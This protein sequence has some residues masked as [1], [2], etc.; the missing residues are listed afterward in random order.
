MALLVCSS[1]LPLINQTVLEFLVN[2]L[3]PHYHSR[4]QKMAAHNRTPTLLHINRRDKAHFGVGFIF[5]RLDCYVSR[6]LAGCELTH[7]HPIKHLRLVGANFAYQIIIV[8]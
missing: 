5:L 2:W 1:F 8:W 4:R 3:V 7:S 6:W